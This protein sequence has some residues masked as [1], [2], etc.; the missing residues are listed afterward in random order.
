MTDNPT[1]GRPI[2]HLPASFGSSAGTSAAE[3]AAL[4]EALE[5][6]IS[7]ARTHLAAIKAAQGERDD[8][9][10]WLA[11]VA[12][13]NARISTTSGSTTCSARSRRGISN[14]S[15]RMTSTGPGS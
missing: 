8:D 4:D 6:V 14:P 12:L 15:R 3:L 13:N 2:N 7:A 1:D 5:Q 9:A 11:Y 10:V